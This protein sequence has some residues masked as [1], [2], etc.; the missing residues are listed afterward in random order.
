MIEIIVF[1][2]YMRLYINILI[3]NYIIPQIKLYTLRD[4]I[5][6]NNSPGPLS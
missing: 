3:I 6:I 2:F 4:Q 1:C 5:I